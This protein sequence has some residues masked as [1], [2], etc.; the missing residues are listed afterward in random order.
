MIRFYSF[1]NFIRIFDQKSK[2]DYVC[3]LHFPKKIEID[4]NIFEYL[5][6]TF[7]ILI[8]IHNDSHPRRFLVITF[9]IFSPIT[10]NRG[11]FL[12]DSYR[13]L[14]K[15]IYVVYATDH[16]KTHHLFSPFFS[17]CA[18]VSFYSILLKLQCTF[19]MLHL[20]RTSSN[21]ICGYWNVSSLDNC[22]L[23]FCREVQEDVCIYLLI[24][25]LIIN[26]F[27]GWFA[28]QIHALGQYW[29]QTFGVS[30]SNSESDFY[31]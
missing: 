17:V 11:S 21:G 18:K 10:R 8:K 26:T 30:L 5:P 13:F 24:L 12:S 7:R 1:L 27:K 23:F 14:K 31:W 6:T 3:I 22:F 25:G 2:F 19:F 4:W 29:Y 15:N 16:S 9:L 28:R 20:L